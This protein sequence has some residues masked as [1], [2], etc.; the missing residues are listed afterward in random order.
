MIVAPSPSTTGTS[1]DAASNDIATGADLL[2]A[3]SAGRLDPPPAAAL[4]DLDLLVVEDGR[5][6]FGFVARPEIGNPVSAHGGILA[7]IA[8][9][10]VSTAVWTVHPADARVVTAD[11]HVSFLKPIE[12]D[13]AEYRCTGWVVH[14]GRSQANALA[15]IRA[16][17][18]D[19]RVQSMATCRILAGRDGQNGR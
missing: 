16:L 5:T 9:F 8:D 10:A 2:R 14:T 13:G 6:V 19:V 7:A 15:E 4:L 3:I 17:D 12:L 11:L 1:P 18:G